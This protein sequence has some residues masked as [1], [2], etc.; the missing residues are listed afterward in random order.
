MKFSKLI[1]VAIVSLFVTQAAHAALGEMAKD[2]VKSGTIVCAEMQ[3][4]ADRQAVAQAGAN[5]EGG[6]PTNATNAL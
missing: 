6:Q 3:K 1:L 2:E 4:K 5:E